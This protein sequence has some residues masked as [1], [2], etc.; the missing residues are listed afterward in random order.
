MGKSSNESREQETCLAHC[1]GQA[2]QQIPW[3]CMRPKQYVSL[4]LLSTCVPKSSAAPIVN[5][6]QGL[7]CS[8]YHCT[9]YRE[10]LCRQTWAPG[11]VIT[12]QQESEPGV[13]ASR[14]QT[15]WSENTDTKLHVLICSRQGERETE[16]IV[17]LWPFYLQEV[18]P[19]GP[20][21]NDTRRN[22]IQ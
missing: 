21:C 8:R 2:L 14:V 15:S 17:F 6:P 18:I 13:L 19:E 1:C 4:T 11:G 10:P 7:W 3:I 20:L 5:A 9:A 22:I 12:Y 16:G